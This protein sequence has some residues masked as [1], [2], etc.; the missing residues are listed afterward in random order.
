MKGKVVGILLLLCLIVP[1][2]ITFTFLHN[3]KKQIKQEVKQQII[4]GINKENLVLLKFSKIES[5]SKFH[6]EGF[7]EF[8]YNGQL[9]DVVEKEIKGDTLYYWCWPDYEETEINKK[10][11]NLVSYVLGHEKQRKESQKRIE[12]FYRSLYFNSPPKWGYFVIQSGQTTIPYRDSYKSISYPPP[13]PP[14]KIS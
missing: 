6:W 12:N 2:A 11:D 9:Y 4:N 13:V 14:P 8:E 3:Q 10:I 1:I 5:K 7:K